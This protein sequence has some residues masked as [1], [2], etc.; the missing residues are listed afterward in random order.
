MPTK[1]DPMKTMKEEGRDSIE[2]CTEH[3]SIGSMPMNEKNDTK[4][5]NDTI[6]TIR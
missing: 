5:T 3:E 4:D 6:R 1:T 2:D